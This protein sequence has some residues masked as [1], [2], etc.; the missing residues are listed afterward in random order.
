[1]KVAYIYLGLFLVI[2]SPM[3]L[4]IQI[5]PPRNLSAE[6]FFNRV[7]EIPEGSIVAVALDYGPGTSAE[8]FGQSIVVSEHLFRRNAKIIFLTL[9]PQAKPFLDSVPQALVKRFKTEGREL[10][11]GEDYVVIGFRPAPA[12]FLDGV[13]KTTDLARFFDRDMNGIPIKSLPIGEKLKNR[14]SIK[15]WF[16]FTGLVGMVQN[17]IQFLR[18]GTET[19]LFHGCTSITVPEA[20]IYLDSGQ[21]HGLLE[22]MP[23]SAAYESL[24]QEHYP[25][26]ESNPDLLRQFV[27]LSFGQLYILGLILLGNILFLTNR[28]S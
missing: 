15:A 22:G 21:I 23:G 18:S 10:V 26:R 25:H 11:Y 14:E 1:M 9:S 7:N 17:Y 28:K 4:S 24:L 5:K 20:H 3:A 2:F 6:T 12:M 27:S 13:M 19:V 8:N 16:Q